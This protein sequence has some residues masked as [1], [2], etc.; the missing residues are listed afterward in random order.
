MEIS[1]FTLWK[2]KYKSTE[3]QP[4]YIIRHKNSK[5]EWEEI[6][7]AWKKTVNGKVD[8]KGNALTYLSCSLKKEVKPEVKEEQLDDFLEYPTESNEVAF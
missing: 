2:N 7:A 5:E 6:G 3:K 8:E 1:N 4:D